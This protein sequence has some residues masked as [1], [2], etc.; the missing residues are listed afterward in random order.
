MAASLTAELLDHARGVLGFD[1]AGVARAEPLAGAARLK[2][3]LAAGRHGEMRHLTDTAEVRADPSRFLPGARSVVC[4]AMSY[5]DPSESAAAAPADG[6]AIARYA[7]RA[8]YHRV[9]RR[10]LVALG[11]FLSDR[12]PGAGWRPAV[13]SAPV[14]ER[15]LAWRAGLGWIG[16]NA[17]LINRRLGSELLLGELVT[18][19][20][21]S[22]GVPEGDQCGTCRACIEA[23]PTDALSE[24]DRLD[25]RR[26]IA[27]LT[28]EHRSALPAGLASALGPHLFGCDICQAVCPWNRHAEPSCNPAL[29]AR[30][31]LGS[32]SAA[33]LA[34]FDEPGWLAV[35]A[36]T[37]LRRLDYPRFRRN[38]EAVGRNLAGRDG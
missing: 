28:V 26:C 23:C 14:L 25:A 6:V 27:Y 35:A 20:E 33:A 34:T 24:A 10:R 37:P 15:E 21:L 29:A 17:C 3:W 11:R 38:L 4:V 30:P 31:H 7:R 5:H 12:V 22:P 13:D 1:L 2:A 8:D 16:R 36:G 19:V 18:D 32:L 9:L